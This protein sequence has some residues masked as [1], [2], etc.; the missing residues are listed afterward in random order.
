ME[1]KAHPIVEASCKRI[2]E[3]KRLQRQLTRGIITAVHN[4]I[5]QLDAYEIRRI[6]NVT[7][8]TEERRSN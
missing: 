5:N 7:R 2:R 3:R 8:K 1:N 4:Y 6:K